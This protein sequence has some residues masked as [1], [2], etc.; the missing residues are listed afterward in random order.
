MIMRCV[1]C[2]TFELRRTPNRKTA[3]LCKIELEAECCPYPE[4]VEVEI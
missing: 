4:Y 1:N 3:L 2:D